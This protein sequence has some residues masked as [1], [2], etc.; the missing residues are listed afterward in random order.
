MR[1][2]VAENHTLGMNWVSDKIYKNIDDIFEP[3]NQ[4]LVISLLA[5]Y[6]YKSTHSISMEICIAACLSEIFLEC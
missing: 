5:D 2:W 1:A 4:P 3:A 6:S